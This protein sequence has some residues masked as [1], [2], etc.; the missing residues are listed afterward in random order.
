MKTVAYEGTNTRRERLQSLHHFALDSATMSR[1]AT[2]V[3]S[4]VWI[5]SLVW[6]LSL[7]ASKMTDQFTNYPC[8]E[9]TLSIN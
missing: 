1:Q 4:H 6:T 3:E 7:V 8:L 9:T 5:L 2:I